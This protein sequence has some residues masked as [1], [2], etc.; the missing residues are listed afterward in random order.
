[1]AG[2][3]FKFVEMFVDPKTGSR[4]DPEPSPKMV[5]TGSGHSFL[6]HR[7]ARVVEHARTI[8]VTESDGTKTT[9]TVVDEVIGEKGGF[10]ESILNL[11][12]QGECWVQS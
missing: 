4:A 9:E 11:S 5:T 10:V 12:Q 6:G 1:M 7:I 8:V 3:K 2:R